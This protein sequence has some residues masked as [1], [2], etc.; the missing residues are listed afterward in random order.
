[1]GGRERLGRGAESREGFS[2]AAKIVLMMSVGVPVRACVDV[3][4]GA[5]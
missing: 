4:E 5:G 3:G 1:M 2:R